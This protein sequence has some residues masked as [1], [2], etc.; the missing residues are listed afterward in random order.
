M[1]ANNQDREIHFLPYLNH[2]RDETFNEADSNKIAPVF[3]HSELPADP[4]KA[5]NQLREY[6]ASTK[7]KKQDRPFPEEKK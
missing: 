4:E 3:T 6:L 1:R 2:K 5:L 7:N